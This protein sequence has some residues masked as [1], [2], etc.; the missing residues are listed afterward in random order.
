MLIINRFKEKQNRRELTWNMA[1]PINIG[2]VC[3]D[4]GK[5]AR[6]L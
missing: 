3:S 2:V 6:A 5:A 1:I 4:F